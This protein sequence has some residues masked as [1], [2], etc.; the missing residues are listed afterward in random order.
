V[1]LLINAKVINSKQSKAFKG[2]QRKV[3]S[4]RYRAQ[5][6]KNIK[7]IIAYTYILYIIAYTQFFVRHSLRLYDF[8]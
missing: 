5:V 6:N 3:F 4:L 1:F 7:Q 8:L 2:L